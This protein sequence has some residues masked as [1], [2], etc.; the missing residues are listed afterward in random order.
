MVQD[1]LDDDVQ[2]N[3]VR[4]FYTRRDQVSSGCLAQQP[5]LNVQSIIKCS[6]TFSFSFP[7]LL[8]LHNIQEFVRSA[9]CTSSL[10]HYSLEAYC[11]LVSTRQRRRKKRKSMLLLKARQ[12]VWSRKRSPATMCDRQVACPCSWASCSPCHLIQVIRPPG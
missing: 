11:C 3:F 1:F 8:L 4:H 9:C 6:A 7:T 2:Y 5:Q 12:K 10:T